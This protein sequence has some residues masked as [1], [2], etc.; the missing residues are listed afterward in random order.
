M[1]IL[2]MAFLA[3]VVCSFAEGGAAV[4]HVNCKTGDDSNNGLTASAAF[5]TFKKAASVLAP[6]DVLELASGVAFHETL[7][8]KS[9][10]TPQNPIVIRGN[11]AV[12]SGLKPVPDGSWKEVKAGLWLSAN[13]VRRGACLPRVLDRSGTWRSVGGSTPDKTDPESLKPGEALWNRDGIWFRPED[14]RKPQDYGLHGFYRNNGF[15]ITGKSYITVHDLVCEHN[16][17]DGFNVH[18]CCA[19]LVFRNIEARY[20]GD[21]GFS[22]H[23]DVQANVYGG[24]FHHNDFGIQDI[25]ASQSSFCGVT[26]VSN[27]LHG[28]DLLGGMRIIRDSV[29]RGNAFGQIRIRGDVVK[30][31][32]WDVA[33]PLFKSRAYLERVTVGPGEGAALSVFRNAEVAVSDCTFSG[34]DR[35]VTASGNAML[36]L[37]KTKIHGCRKEP[38]VKQPGSTVV[39]TACEIASHRCSD[40]K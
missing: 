18:G 16:A 28:V 1:S 23:E 11:G 7:V 35:G 24:F 39:E 31:M 22:V 15:E 17:N 20:N 32:G 27:R 40:P 25:A 12:I 26:V 10:G 21:D 33:N 36:H 38:L 14:G 3:A 2:K 9:S 34:T 4:Y 30:Y 6:G 19:G 5:K 13:G 37:V 29:I 8:M